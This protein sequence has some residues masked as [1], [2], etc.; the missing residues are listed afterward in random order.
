MGRNVEEINVF[1]KEIKDR[2][3]S[4]EEELYD[5]LTF[6][7]TDKEEVEKDS[8]I[9][10]EL[11][12]KQ[13]GSYDCYN[14]SLKMSFYKKEENPF[15]YVVSNVTAKMYAKKI[16]H[17]YFQ[18]NED[19]LK[20]C[21]SDECLLSYLKGLKQ[22]IKAGDLLAES[23]FTDEEIMHLDSTINFLLDNKKARDSILIIMRIVQNCKFD[24]RFNELKV[25]GYNDLYEIE[26][27]N[28]MSGFIFIN[29]SSLIR[30]K[31]A[32]TIKIYASIK[33]GKIVDVMSDFGTYLVENKI[34]SFAKTRPNKTNDMLTVRVEDIKVL[35]KVVEWLKNNE[36]IYF[37]RHP[38]MPNVEG[39]PITLDDGGAYN[40]FLAKTLFSYLTKSNG[41]LSFDNFYEYLNS[42]DY[43]DGINSRELMLFDKN[44][45]LALGE[46][47]NL[48]EFKDYYSEADND[49]KKIVDPPKEKAKNK[50]TTTMEM[51]LMCLCE[52]NKNYGEA[53][54]KYV[55]NEENQKKKGLN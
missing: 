34:K 14:T 36:N 38:F 16:Y 30:K 2:K 6:Y 4:S 8:N 21:E 24:Y 23:K 31:V 37:N 13:I 40:D 10:D 45:K 19:F 32:P 11:T 51:F 28:S 53:G 44:L 1:L 47:I 43:K 52:H 33:K 54:K 7:N 55:D 12:P 18:R 15:D 46:E 41:E 27:S 3:I 50:Q 35:D 20:A 25:D 22:K 39:V 17:E 26:V 49:Y 48:E 42:Q 29:T 9:Y 5:S